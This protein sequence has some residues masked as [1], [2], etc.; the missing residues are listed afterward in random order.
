MFVLASKLIE[1]SY[2]GETDLVA[3]ADLINTCKIA[4][5]LDGGVLVE[6]LKHDFDDPD[7]NPNRDVRLWENEAGQVYGYAG[8]Y[9]AKHDSPTDSIASDG[10]H[11]W[12]FF[13][14]HPDRRNGK[15]EHQILS[16][17][18]DHI[19]AIGQEWQ[20]PVFKVR[21]GSRN[22]QSHQQA[23]LT[24][25]GFTVDRYF[26]RMERSLLNS[27]PQP[28]FPAGFSLRPLQDIQELPVWIEM[29]NQSFVDHWSFEPETL[30]YRQHWMEQPSYEAEMDLVAI[31]PDGTFAAFCYSSIDR[32]ENSRT[33]C[34]EGWVNLLGTRRGF[35]KMGLG[36]AMLLTALQSLK[37]RGMETA[38][39]GVDSENPSGALRLYES[40][41]FRKRYTFLTYGK[42]VVIS[43]L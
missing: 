2:A 7:F 4:D 29:F 27:I 18:E 26:Y 41:D 23:L 16:W 8:L 25:A 3:I 33:G 14:I 43:G 12:L 40:V 30:E 31:A 15:L 1:R 13:Y 6:S 19:Q 9:L 42:D 39:L 28:Q 22:D 21:A 17:A 34:Q 11:G 20:L 36:R 24:Q 32:Q 35:R 5:H 10:H 38:L 37:S